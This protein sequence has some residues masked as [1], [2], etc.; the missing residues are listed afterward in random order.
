MSDLQARLDRL[1]KAGR[2]KRRPARPAFP[3]PTSPTSPSLPTSVQDLRDLPDVEEVESTAGRFLLRT[4]R[5]D[6][7]HRQGQIALKELLQLPPTAAS[8]LASAD[9]LADIDFRQAVFID[10][11]TS[12]LAGGAGTI[13]FLTGVG[14][15]EEGDY[16][17]RQYFARTPAEEPA[18][19]AHL[20]EFLSSA[21]SL[22]SFNGKAFDI[23][24]LRT[25]FILAGLAPNFTRL[26]HLD[27]L[28]PARRLWRS[29][30]GSCTFGRLERYIL[31]H[32][33]MIL[34]IPSWQIPEMWFRFAR[35]ENNVDEISSIFYHNQEDVV[36]MAPLAQ[37]LGG[38]LA[39]VLAPHPSDYLAVARYLRRRGDIDRAEA[40]YLQALEQPQSTSQ[41]GETMLELAA[42]LKR[43]R[44]RAAALTWWEAAAELP[45]EI[46]PHI[47]LA[48]YH[49]WESGD[50]DQ[51]LAWTEQAIVRVQ[52]WR[53]SAQRE[54][55]LAALEH[56]KQRLQ[57]KR[58]KTND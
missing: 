24:L 44:G 58:L 55:I 46:L 30:L 22:I 15:Y 35:G 48:K 53:V 2:L 29:R 56:R 38:V 16:V 10:T 11:E 40:A 45:A 39:G 57:R 41:R 19:L 50:L 17:V 27:L 51:A 28:H 31:Q 6:L 1:R 25:R 12:G 52:A 9:L 47:E 3:A 14:R 49:E 4:V 36:S 18:Y 7:N 43:E 33:R 13:V 32:Q 21:Q 42:M 54:D 20:A 26:P 37:A 23:P 8:Y 34:D 5:Y